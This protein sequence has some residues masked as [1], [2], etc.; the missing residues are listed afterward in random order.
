MVALPISSDGGPRDGMSLTMIGVSLVLGAVA[1][2]L[3][4]GALRLVMPGTVAV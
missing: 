1:G 4:F 2:T 3:G